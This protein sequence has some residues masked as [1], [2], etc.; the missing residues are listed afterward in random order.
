MSWSSISL[1]PVLK[2]Y[3]TTANAN[4]PS[5]QC[6]C[7]LIKCSNES[8]LSIQDTSSI[9]ISSPT[10]S[11]LVSARSSTTYT[12]LTLVWPRGSVTQRLVSISRTAMARI[13]Q[14]R[15]AMPPWTHTW[16]LSR[17]VETTLNP[18]ASSL[19]TSI[20]AACRGKAS[21]LA[22]RKK[23]MRRSETR[24]CQHRLRPSPR[25]FQTNSAFISTIAA[26]LSLRRSP[27]S[28]T[29][30]S[31]LRTSSTGWATSMTSSSTG[32]WRN[33]ALSSKCEATQLKMMMQTRK[34]VRLTQVSS[35]SAQPHLIKFRWQWVSLL[36]LVELPATQELW[37]ERPHNSSLRSDQYK[38]HT[39]MT[40]KQTS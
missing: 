14:E 1:D 25:T 11:S 36:V 15:R 29:S 23:N 9:V 34:K 40:P 28:A 24:S 27:T 31:Y 21:P 19:C 10:T 32:W 38:S 6:W 7:W 35:Q 13:W 37:T 33:R 30:E 18:S 26:V 2:T 4:S 3:S 16:A 39:D 8:S 22:P 12:L 17:V 20:R 5:K